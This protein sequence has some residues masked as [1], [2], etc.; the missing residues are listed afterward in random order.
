MTITDLMK[1]ARQYGWRAVAGG[2]GVDFTKGDHYLDVSVDSSG[3][4]VEA[5]TATPPHNQGPIP[6]ATYESCAE[7]LKEHA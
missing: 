6:G 2:G 3:D 4:L 5:W 1:V 7:F